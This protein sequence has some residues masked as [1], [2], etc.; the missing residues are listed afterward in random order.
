MSQE[1]VLPL[2]ARSG[3]GLVLLSRLAATNRTGDTARAVSQKNVEIV[4]AGFEVWN[5]GDMDAF[6]ELFDPDVILR[7]PEGWPEPGPYVGLEAV[8][9]QLEQQRDTW[10]ADTFELISDFI[11]AADRVV[12]RVIWRGAGQGPESNIEFT[13]VYTV[14]KGRILSIEHFW[15][16]AEAL[17]A[18]GLSEQDAHADP[19]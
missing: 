19:T 15:D 10:D 14:R 18:V 1:D 9:R 6:R 13:G 17:E 5:A 16:H 8:M 2:C 3:S 4:R 12:V 7:M 11:D